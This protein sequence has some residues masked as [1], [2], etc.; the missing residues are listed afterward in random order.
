MRITYG[1]GGSTGPLLLINVESWDQ[2]SHLGDF[3]F[4]FGTSPVSSVNTNSGQTSFFS[5]L[6]E[7]GRARRAGGCPVDSRNTIEKEK[8]SVHSENS[9]SSNRPAGGRRGGVFFFTYFILA[10]DSERF[11]FDILCSLLFSYV[12]SLS[13]LVCSV[14]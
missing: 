5:P 12:G 10:R 8:T 4:W 6:V 14:R 2:G 11:P 9:F 13:S 3:I 1:L 7:E